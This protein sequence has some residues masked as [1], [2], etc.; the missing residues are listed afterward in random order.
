MSNWTP[1]DKLIQSYSSSY[2]LYINSKIWQPEEHKWNGTKISPKTERKLF[3]T[4]ALVSLIVANYFQV[5]ATN[6]LSVKN[7]IMN[8]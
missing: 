2:K 1:I 4:T 6:R 7:V 3:S 5:L 8:T